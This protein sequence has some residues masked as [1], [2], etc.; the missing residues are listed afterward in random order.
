MYEK[1][2]PTRNNANISDPARPITLGV[3]A[4]PDNGSNSFNA[5]TSTSAKITESMPSSV[6]P[7]HAAQKPMICS[8]LSVVLRGSV[9]PMARLDEF[10][11][12]SFAIFIGSLASGEGTPLLSA[13]RQYKR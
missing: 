5:G 1:P 7:D 9:S 13:Q 2:Q 6:Q 10:T 12:V 8:R 3:A 11:P 4:N